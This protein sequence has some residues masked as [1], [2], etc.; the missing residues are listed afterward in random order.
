MEDDESTMSGGEH[1]AYRMHLKG[2]DGDDGGSYKEEALRLREVLAGSQAGLEGK[3]LDQVRRNRDLQVR[4]ESE[5]SKVN[6]L[7]ARVVSLEKEKA[8]REALKSNGVLMPSER[9]STSSGKPGDGNTPVEGSLTDLEEKVDRG[10]KTIQLLRRTCDEQKNNIAKLRRI[11]QSELGADEEQLETVLRTTAEGGTGGWK[12][13]AQQISLLKGKIKDLERAMRSDDGGLCGEAVGDDAET[14]SEMT[15]RTGISRITTTTTVKDFDDVNRSAV[16]QKQKRVFDQARDLKLRVEEK[17][18][19]YD[20]EKKKSESL[21]ARLQILERDNQHLKSCIQRV[22]DKTENDNN[23]IDAYRQE[24]DELRAENRKL[25][26]IAGRSQ[27]P[28]VET[29]TQ[30]ETLQRENRR[31]VDTIES[32]RS[33][34]RSQPPLPAANGVSSS[35]S[36][37]DTTVQQALTVVEQ[38]RQT[39]LALES[40]MQKR[41]KATSQKFESV[42]DCD[43]AMREEN[44]S[45]KYRCAVLSAMMEKEIEL[46]K[47]VAQQQQQQQRAPSANTTSR[48]TSGAIAGRRAAPSVSQE[49]YDSLKSQYDELRRAFNAK[50]SKGS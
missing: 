19:Q 8:E 16:E 4:F 31:L 27:Q 43:A 23:L 42:S 41:D 17:E 47:A 48:P 1:D 50:Q 33:K 13:R 20:E 40:Q 46:H 45:L 3:Y 7:T 5:K 38:Q 29:N 24:L 28:V 44:N 11:L 32:L 39:I 49:E 15:V 37:S 9:G 30:I 26:V 18:K 35:S 14:R 10:N 22:L 2:G 21:Q 12:G 34:E 6:K 36:S 25:Q